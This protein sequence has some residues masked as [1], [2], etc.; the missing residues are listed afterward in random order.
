MLLPFLIQM[1]LLMLRGD[2][3]GAPFA[4]N[5]TRTDHRPWRMET[6]ES[7]CVIYCS[8]DDLCLLFAVKGKHTHTHTLP[9]LPAKGVGAQ[10]GSEMAFP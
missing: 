5:T 7:M 4:T 9:Y 2:A 6:G 10:N 8:F 1:P 3:T